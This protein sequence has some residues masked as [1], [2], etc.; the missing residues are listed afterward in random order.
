MRLQTIS[1]WLVS[2]IYLDIY[3]DTERWGHARREAAKRRSGSNRSI[4]RYIRPREL[5]VPKN[6]KI[7]RV[8]RVTLVTLANVMTSP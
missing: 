4:L 5:L 2:V 7:A 6:P 3:K 8:T 1:R